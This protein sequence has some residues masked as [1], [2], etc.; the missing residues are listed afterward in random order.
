M[1]G[2]A[3][4]IKPIYNNWIFKKKYITIGKIEFAAANGTAVR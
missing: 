4:Q 1:A 2:A 3:S